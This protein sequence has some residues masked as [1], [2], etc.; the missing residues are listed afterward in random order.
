MV[1]VIYVRVSTEDQAR[2]GYSL[3]A[4]EE[5]CRRKAAE[6]GADRM[7][8]YRDEA[9]TGEILERPG[10]QA[11][12][13]AAKDAA[14]F[15]AYDPD[16]LSR[17]L[18]HQL[19]L[20]DAVEKAGCRLEFV[21]M[22]WQNTPEGRLFY[23]LRG[24]IAEYE[25]EKFKMRSQLGRLAKARRGFLPFD[26]RTYGYRY[27][28]GRYQ[29]DEAKAPVYRRMVE[30]ALAGKSMGE[31]A[32]QLNAEGVP[33]PQGDRWYRQTVRKILKNPVYTGTLYVNCYD[34][35]GHK[36][37]RQQGMSASLR[38]RP[39]EEWIPIPVPPLI[40][41]EEW[42]LLQR[43]LAARR[44]GNQGGRTYDYYLAGLVYCGHC[45]GGMS[46]GYGRSSTGQVYRYYICTRA[47]PSVR[48][49]RLRTPPCPGN[50]HRADAIEEAVWARVREWLTDPE[51]LARAVRDNES[52]G[53]A[54]KEASRIRKRLAQLD[55]ERE[56]AFEAFRRGLVDV[57]MFEKAVREAQAEKAVL[58]A[59]LRQLEEA[60][61]AAAYAEQNMEALREM[62][63]QVAGRIDDLDWKDREK[64]IRLLVRRVTV[65][66]GELVVETRISV[67]RGALRRWNEDVRQGGN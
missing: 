1:A 46:G 14:F 53:L 39:E 40:S 66:G 42:G 56:R 51:A 3:E 58:E 24:A 7:E 52:A 6:L 16:R 33:A 57:E 54:E 55:R 28:E 13:A 12:L 50:R 5:A 10:L 35:E 21:T 49:Q 60:A 65:H 18:A 48:A 8:V 67:T 41:R 19:L 47:W 43:V 61:Q 4:Q 30:M 27:S 64:L 32:A 63:R 29:V 17:R 38:L 59:K 44:R 31:I 26:P 45:D 22:D 9:F 62:A 37:A 2:H 20:A 34:T 25:K 23:S 36:A 15:I 11:A